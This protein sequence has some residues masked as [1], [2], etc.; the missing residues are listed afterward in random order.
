M[1]RVAC[2]TSREVVASVVKSSDCKSRGRREG[3]SGRTREGGIDVR[4]P[5]RAVRYDGFIC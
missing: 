2:L 1:C 5:E 3:S 4:M